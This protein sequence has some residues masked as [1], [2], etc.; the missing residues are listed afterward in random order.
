AA[1]VLPPTCALLSCGRRRRPSS[2]RGRQKP[3]P[4][5]RHAR[6]QADIHHLGDELNRGQPW[7]SGADYKRKATLDKLRNH[8]VFHCEL[9]GC[10]VEQ[11]ENNSPPHR[12]EN[13]V[14]D[15]DEL[16]IEEV[17]PWAKE[18]HQR[19]RRYI[20]ISRATRRKWVQGQGGATYVDLYCGTGRAVIRDT[21]E[22]IDGS[23]LVAFKCALLQEGRE[24]ANTDAGLG[25]IWRISGNVADP[26]IRLV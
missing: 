17:G 11:I 9:R 14:L 4:S 15:D 13:K 8:A 12:T 7:G 16:P 22:K 18:K 3:A 19:L 23:P 21:G 25:F 20:D 5:R 26:N 24:N 1:R 6:A 2:C 10:I